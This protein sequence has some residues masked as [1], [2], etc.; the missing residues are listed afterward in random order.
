MSSQIDLLAEFLLQKFV[1][2]HELDT[3]LEETP[4]PPSTP[5]APSRTKDD[6]WAEMRQRVHKLGQYTRGNFK[7]WIKSHS[8]DMLRVSLAERNLHQ[9]GSK[10]E[11]VKRLTEDIEAEFSLA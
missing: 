10:E 6:R 5:V 3:A 8:R 11:L 4:T 9:N 7:R 2:A 1:E